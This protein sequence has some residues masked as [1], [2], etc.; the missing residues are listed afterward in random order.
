MMRTGHHLSQTDLAK[1]LQISPNYLYMIEAGIRLPSI[2]VL[3][4]FSVAF[5]MNLQFLKQYYLNDYLTQVEI[6]IKRKLEIT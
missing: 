3:Q 1:R 5:E 2:S 4:R 6:K